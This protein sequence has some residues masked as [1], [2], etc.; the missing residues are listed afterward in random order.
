MPVL[1]LGHHRHAIVQRL[2][3]EPM[4]AQRHTFEDVGP[5]VDVL[6]RPQ[7]LV[8]RARDEAHTPRSVVGRKRQD[9]DRPVLL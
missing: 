1:D 7:R 9:R 4:R 5:Y 6:E 8:F 2:S 3:I